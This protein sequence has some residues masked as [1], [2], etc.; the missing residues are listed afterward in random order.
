L[1]GIGVVVYLKWY[2]LLVFLGWFIAGLDAQDLSD[3]F[4]KK[5]VLREY[6]WHFLASSM[7]VL[8]ALFGLGIYPLLPP[9]LGGGHLTPIRFQFSPG[10]GID[11]SLESSNLL[12]DEVD[13]GYYIVRSES[14]NS[15][16]FIPR[17]VIT[18]AYFGKQK[19]ATATPP[20]TK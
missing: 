20:P 15:S 17:G 16:V 11:K 6:N 10:A 3:L 13:G 4:E 14:D 19:T 1:A 18:L 7:F 12:V 9:N 2:S 5:I 8:L